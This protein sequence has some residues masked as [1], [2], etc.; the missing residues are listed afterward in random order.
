M[1]KYR[2]ESNTVWATCQ[3]LHGELFYCVVAGCGD[4]DQVDVGVLHVHVP[5]PVQQVVVG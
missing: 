2:N 3:P 5:V 1:F 4:W